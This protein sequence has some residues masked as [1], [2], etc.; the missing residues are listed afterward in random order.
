MTLLQ[1]NR[2]LDDTHIEAS[3]LEKEDITSWIR[4]R[5]LKAKTFQPAAALQKLKGLDVFEPND[6]TS[7]PPPPPFAPS[8]PQASDGDSNVTRAHWQKSYGGDCCLD[9]TCQRPLGVVNGCVNC[10]KCGQ[11]F[12]E[13]HTMYQ[14]RLSRSAQH[15]PV[16]GFWSRVCETCYKSR[17]GYNDHNGVVVDHTDVFRLARKR[18]VERAHLDVAR[19]EKRVT[20]VCG[21]IPVCEVSTDVGSS[22]NCSST[23][24]R[25]HRTTVTQTF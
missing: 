6:L 19:L 16:R 5:V 3:P 20:K 14:I 25:R 11:L 15:E 10:R 17:R 22:R 7:S 21:A 12:C 9:P 8:Q 13:E 23:R 18:K 24:R 4:K 1:L 2:H